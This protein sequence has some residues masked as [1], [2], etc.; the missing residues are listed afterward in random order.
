MRVYPEGYDVVDDLRGRVAKSRMIRNAPFSFERASGNESLGA[1][2]EA[3]LTEIERL[4]QAIG[5]VGRIRSA[6][7]EHSALDTDA[8][9]LLT[10]R[11]TVGEQYARDTVLTPEDMFRFV[12][13]QA[14][15]SF[16]DKLEEI[17][18]TPSPTPEVL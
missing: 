14:M 3:L 10:V 8:G 6:L 9:L 2:L 5:E 7:R 16:T 18:A 15:A 1:F 17:R 4:Q 13:E 11:F 12:Y